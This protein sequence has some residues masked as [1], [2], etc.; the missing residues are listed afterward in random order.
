MRPMPAAYEGATP[1]AGVPAPVREPMVPAGSSMAGAML[2][3]LTCWPAGWP[4]PE[5]PPPSR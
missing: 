1:P 2:P 4:L 3:P 5:L